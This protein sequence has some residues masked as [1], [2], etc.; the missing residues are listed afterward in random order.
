MTYRSIRFG[1]I[2]S[3]PVIDF[4][5]SE[6]QRY[7]KQ[8]DPE[9][10]VD[11]LQVKVVN[12]DFEN[13]I[14]VGLDA[15]F[16]QYVPAVEDAKLD[17]AVVICVSQGCGY[18]TGSNAR[19][20]LLGVYRFLR[21]LGC[22]WV[23]PGKAGE[24]IPAVHIDRPEVHVCETPSYRY[25]GVAIEGGNSYENIY[26]TIDFLPKVGMNAYEVQFLQPLTFFERWYEHQGNRFLP[27]E[28]MTRDQ[29]MA[30]VVKA[31]AEIARRGICYLKTGHG[32]TCEPFGI[33]GTN[34]STTQTYIIPEGVD[35]HFALINGKRALWDNVPLNTNLC[36]SNPETRRIV[37]EAACRYC[38]EHKMLDVL[39]FT[40]ADG[41]NNHCECEECLKKRPSD[42]YVVLLNE[43]DDAL[44]AA[45]L[46]IK[47]AFATYQDTM[48]IPA[49]EKLN[50]PERFILEFAPITRTYGRNYD[51]Y[52]TCDDPLP[53]FVHNKLETSSS[54]AMN[55]KQLRAWQEVFQ[56]DSFIFDYH[57]MWAHLNDFG[58]EYCAKNLAA[59][60]K[61]LH[62]IGMNGM[63]SCQV[64]RSF[65]PTALPFWMM[66]SALW[67]DT[68]DE[69]KVA[70]DYYRSA[71]GEDW[72]LVRSYLQ[73]VSDLLLTYE[74]PWD[75]DPEKPRGPFCKDY[76]HLKSVVADFTPVIDRNIAKNTPCKNDWELLRLH[77]KY[78]YLALDTMLAVENGDDV[79]ADTAI[80]ALLDWM[81]MNEMALLKVLDVYNTRRFWIKRLHLEGPTRGWNEKDI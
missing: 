56:G 77:G 9:L 19:S 27:Q 18:I 29:I 1:Q 47:V 65:F 66:A 81:A 12:P 46:D 17:D 62:K 43:L 73:T 70:E 57:L 64:Q 50:K 37:V 32:W 13:V 11:I 31:E 60:M 14:W 74:D 58:G 51:E 16:A 6:L 42:W 59:D 25:R 54:L 68:C 20:V 26:E 49:V 76:A 21:E 69:Q 78:V 36:Y 44:T 39:L 61:A 5:V 67:D 3:D 80:E 22:R 35:K 2:G 71:F 7:L 38:Q 15:T 28:P 52:L 72:S 8:M 79:T 53:P 10:I 40:L 41:A 63:M 75:G 23:R 33:P 34:W 45:G 4:S 55:L 24:R 48:W 30:M